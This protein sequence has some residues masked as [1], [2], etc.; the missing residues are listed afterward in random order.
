[1][2]KA[3]RGKFQFES[4]SSDDSDI[5]GKKDRPQYIRTTSKIPRLGIDDREKR[6]FFSSS[7]DSQADPFASNESLDNYLPSPKKH[8]KMN[9][10]HVNVRPNQYSHAHQKKGQLISNKSRKGNEPNGAYDFD[11]QFDMISMGKLSTASSSY[12][13]TCAENKASHILS[14]AMQTGEKNSN[15]ENRSAGVNVADAAQSDVLNDVDAVNFA[16]RIDTKLNEILAR[17]A[18]LEKAMISSATNSSS[19][20]LKRVPDQLHSDAEIFMK[21]NALPAKNLNELKKFDANLRDPVFYTATVSAH[22]VILI[23]RSIIFFRCI[24]VFLLRYILFL[25]A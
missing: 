16:K 15:E 23:C 19:K 24:N 25:C 7:D 8:K 10:V 22:S 11:S 2:S 21:S 17:V 13:N 6:M 12:E 14:N 3:K 18:T 20:D 5:E 4:T 9:T 1:M